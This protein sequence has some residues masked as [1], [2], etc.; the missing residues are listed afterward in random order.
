MNLNWPK[1]YMSIADDI[2]ICL[3]FMKGNWRKMSEKH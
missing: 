3:I 2:I 1:T